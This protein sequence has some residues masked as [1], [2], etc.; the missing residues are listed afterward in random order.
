MRPVGGDGGGEG[1]RY[2]ENSCSLTN[3]KLVLYC[4]SKK[5]L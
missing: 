5:M 3:T 2:T 1:K 4:I